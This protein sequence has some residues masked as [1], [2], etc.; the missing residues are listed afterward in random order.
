LW[1]AVGNMPKGKMTIKENTFTGEYRYNL[2]NKGRINIPSKFRSALSKLSNENFVIT[3]G[4]DSCIVA[5]PLEEWQIRVESGLRELSST[6][7]KN[8]KLVRSITRFANTVKLDAQ[9]RIQI[10]PNLKEYA[11]LE[12]EVIIIGVVNKIEIWNPVN[13]SK[14]EDITPDDFDELEDKVIL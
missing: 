14:M 13:L 2:D 7:S 11:D 8:R 6:S 3:K 9:G 4:M 10:T 5:Y 12:K 1:G